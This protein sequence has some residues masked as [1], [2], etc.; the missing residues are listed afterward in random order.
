MTTTHDFSRASGD[1]LKVELDSKFDAVIDITRSDD[2]AVDFTS[3]TIKLDIM[4][5]YGEDPVV[6]LTSGTEITISTNRLTF[7][8]TFSELSRRKYVYELYNDTDKI[9][10]AKGDF[11]VI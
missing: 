11:I 1:H 3:K 8:K 6:T 9:S 7:N 5:K 10:I 2:G 4:T